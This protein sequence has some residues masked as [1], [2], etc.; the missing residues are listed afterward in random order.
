MW[1]K[2]GWMNFWKSILIYRK[3]IIV[4]KEYKLP[5]FCLYRELPM[6]QQISINEILVSVAWSDS[7][8]NI[9]LP[10]NAEPY[11]H[12]KIT[13]VNFESEGTAIWVH[14]ETES[15]QKIALPLDFI[16]NIETS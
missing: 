8:H 6:A 15:K 2:V 5:D 10:N 16:L 1:L 4:S 11:N 9:I 7:R 13:S 12:V 14:F 3:E